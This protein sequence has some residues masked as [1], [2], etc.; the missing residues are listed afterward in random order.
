[1]IVEL[2][3]GNF[4]HTFSSVSQ[5]AESTQMRSGR[6][7]KPL[8]APRRAHLLRKSVP[9][10]PPGSGGGGRADANPNP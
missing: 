10:G 4:K 3:H 1:M 9:A 7:R 5:Q 8:G 2:V 6:K